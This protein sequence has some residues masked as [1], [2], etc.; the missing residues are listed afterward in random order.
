MMNC[1]VCGTGILEQ[2]NLTQNIEI[3][4]APII[5]VPVDVLQ[6]S[7][8]KE[9]VIAACSFLNRDWKILEHLV[10]HYEANTKDLPQPV[11][12]WMK[13]QLGL[14]EQPTTSNQFVL[15]QSI[16]NLDLRK[17]RHSL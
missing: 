1:D 12:H 8:C 17:Y 13:N 16:K 11:A 6:C 9:S 2:K 10:G 5:V 3:E 7:D 4:G 14:G 15:N